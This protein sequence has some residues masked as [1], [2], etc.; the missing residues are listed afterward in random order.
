MSTSGRRKANA[1]KEL[2]FV[3]DPTRI[4]A[5]DKER[6]KFVG[7]KTA[8]LIGMMATTPSAPPRRTIHQSLRFGGSAGCAL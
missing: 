2:V 1:G 4:G 7:E 3:A 5:D 8:E 6:S